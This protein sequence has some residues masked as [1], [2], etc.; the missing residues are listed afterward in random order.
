[1]G[2]SL[3]GVPLFI[4]ELVVGCLSSLRRRGSQGIIHPGFG[5]Q[6]KSLAQGRC[7]KEIKDLI[8]LINLTALAKKKKGESNDL[9]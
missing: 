5:T 2:L 6:S 1:M 4:V 3:V 9:K 8:F 7:P